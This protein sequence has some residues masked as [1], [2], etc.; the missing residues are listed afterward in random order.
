MYSWGH[1]RQNQVSQAC[2]SNCIPQNT[3]RDTCFWHQSAEL[4]FVFCQNWYDQLIAVDTE[5]GR[6]HKAIVEFST[7]RERNLRESYYSWDPA[8]KGLFSLAELD[9]FCVLIINTLRPRQNGRHFADDTFKCIFLN[10]NELIPT[11]NLLKFVPK[12]PIN[13]IPTLDDGLAP[14][15]RQAIIWI[16][17]G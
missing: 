13:N 12:G 1:W 3:A 14:F 7:N 2:I 4:L 5:R 15:R 9:C 16:N 10:E 8:G 11:K 6:F 17:V